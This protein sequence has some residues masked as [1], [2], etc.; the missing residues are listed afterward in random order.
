MRISR[1]IKY[2]FTGDLEA[3]VVRNPFFQGKEKHLLKCQILRITASCTVVPRTM[4][5]VNPEDKKEI[6]LT[7]EWKFPSFEF[8]GK[9]DNWVHH[10][11]A[12]LKNGR[13][14]H[15]KP[16]IPEGQADVDEEKLIKEIEAK[17]PFEERLKPLSGDKCN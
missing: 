2:L 3:P 5:S 10:P 14:T 11:Q 7:A 4:Y 1:K 16:E 9:I 15:L 17:D 13:L 6:D 8:L 12:I